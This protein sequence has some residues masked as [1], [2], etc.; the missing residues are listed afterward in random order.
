[1]QIQ[2]SRRSVHNAMRASFVALFL[3]QG[4]L[5]VIVFVM[6]GTINYFESL[7]SPAWLPALVVAIE[8]FL[9]MQFGLAMGGF[10]NAPPAQ[11]V[12]KP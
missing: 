12:S 10:Y 11:G 8:L 7:G 6:P 3:A 1:M 2:L 9:I 5:K 4:L